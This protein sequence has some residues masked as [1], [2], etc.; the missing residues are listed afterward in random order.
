MYLLKNNN[1][2]NDKPAAELLQDRSVTV[3]RPSSL[4]GL[5]SNRQ[6]PRVQEVARSR[7]AELGG[8]SAAAATY[9]L[10]K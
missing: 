2:H 4:P 8:L 5:E 9:A 10:E 7:R 3:S 6:W 1:P